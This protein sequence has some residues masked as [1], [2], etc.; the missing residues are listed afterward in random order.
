M[1]RGVVAGVCLVYALALGVGAA[2]TAAATPPANDDFAAAEAIEI[3]G[4]PY[5]FDNYGATSEP[6][7]PDHRGEAGGASVWFKWTAPY[8]GGAFVQ[9]CPFEVGRESV[10]AVYSGSTLA[11]LAAAPSIQPY[12]KCSFIFFATAGVT[13]SIAVDGVRDPISGTAEMFES[14]LTIHRT[15][16]N[17]D[18]EDALSLADPFSGP[19]KS[20]VIAGF[21]NTG[22]TKQ[23]GEPD[24]AGNPGGASVWATW[25]APLTGSVHLRLCQ[26][27]FAALLAVYTGSSVTALTPVASGPGTLSPGCPTNRNAAG[28]V[29]FDITAGTTY[30]IA[31][32]GVDGAT[33]YTNLELWTSDEPVQ[34]PAAPSPAEP[35]TTKIADRKLDGAKRTATFS[36]RSDVA[37]STFRCKLD[38]G[39]FRR[40][41]KRMVF[42]HLSP[43]RHTFRAEAISPSGLLDKTPAK[44]RFR[45]ARRIARG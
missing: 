6:G 44:S 45:F 8:T 21:R 31:I 35:P 37:G 25:T 36:L 1:R 17:D 19:Y 13:Y 5:R 40:C 20:A 33:G 29:S 34:A 10:V 11:T 14:G 16:P 26:A 9:A 43:G 3:R 38:R 23:P 15:P 30:D 2:T 39:A 12:G 42:R 18:F 27:D 22:A 28:G 32:D 7:E 4:L 24:H 41:A